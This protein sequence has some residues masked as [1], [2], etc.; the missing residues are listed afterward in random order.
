MVLGLIKEGTLDYDMIVIDNA[1]VLAGE[2][3]EL[4]KMEMSDYAVALVEARQLIANH[5][6]EMAKI[7]Q[8]T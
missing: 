1:G 8:S 2:I 7:I 6:D 4:L 5:F 3:D